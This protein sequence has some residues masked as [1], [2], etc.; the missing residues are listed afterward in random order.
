[1]IERKL[2]NSVKRVEG[3]TSDDIYKLLSRGVVDLVLV[4]EPAQSPPSSTALAAKLERLDVVLDSVP[5]YH[6]LAERHR[7]VGIRL[8]GVLQRMQNS[9]ELQKIRVKAVQE[10]P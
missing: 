8:N 10:A 9:G 4:V 7:D 1:M 5:L 2:G 3:A 6:Y